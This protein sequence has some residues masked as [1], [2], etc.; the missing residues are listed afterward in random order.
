MLGRER[1]VCGVGIRGGFEGREGTI[2]RE[3][4]WSGRKVVGRWRGMNVGRSRGDGGGEVKRWRER[5]GRMDKRE[6]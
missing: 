4:R 2:G 1:K 3:K 6:G 5:E